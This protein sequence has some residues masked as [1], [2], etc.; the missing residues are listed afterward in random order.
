[1]NDSQLIWETYWNRPTNPNS[2]LIG[3]LI[4]SLKGLGFENPA[5]A[6][7]RDMISLRYTSAQ[8]IPEIPAPYI[9]V[10]IYKSDGKTYGYLYTYNPSTVQSKDGKD[11][12]LDTE[13]EVFDFIS[14]IE[15]MIKK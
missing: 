8:A 15:K 1:M 14:K 3:Y 10:D 5:A 13:D 2:K 7:D 6:A 9:D 12:S 11:Y 4:K